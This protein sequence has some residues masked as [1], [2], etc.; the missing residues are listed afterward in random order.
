MK[1]QIIGVAWDKFNSRLR[2][3]VLRDLL[4]LKDAMPELMIEMLAPD[5]NVSWFRALCE[6][7]ACPIVV[8]KEARVWRVYIA[9]NEVE[10][11]NYARDIIRKDLRTKKATPIYLKPNAENYPTIERQSDN[12]IVPPGM[13][14][15][16]DMPPPP[17][18]AGNQPVVL[19]R[20]YFYS[21]FI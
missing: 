16:L 20:N 19:P 12:R 7:V 1:T 6:Y 3:E 17:R 8:G 4:K 18:A 2:G 5:S 15:S 21:P 10:L 13:S 14:I 9:E 11:P